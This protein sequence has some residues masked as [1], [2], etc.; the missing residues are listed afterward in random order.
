MVLGMSLLLQVTWLTAEQEFVMLT[1]AGQIFGF[2]S[3]QAV[4]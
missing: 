1:S 2:D 4:Y 3:A